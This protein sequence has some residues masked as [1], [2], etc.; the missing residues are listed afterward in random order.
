MK[1]AQ[2]GP[3]RRVQE[4][5]WVLKNYVRPLG[6]ARFGL[7]C[8][9]MGTGMAFPWQ[10]LTS[11]ELAS[12]HLVEDVKLGL[13]L[14]AGGR[15]PLFCPS[16][17][18]ESTFP[19]SDSGILTQRQRW[20]IGSTRTLVQEGPR[21]LWRGLRTGNR[22]LLVLAL[23]LLVPPVSLLGG[24]VGLVWLTC[25]AAALAGH[26]LMPLVLATTAGL[27][28]AGSLVLAWAQFGRQILAMRDIPELASH[29]MQKVRI[30]RRPGHL[31]QWIR[32]DRS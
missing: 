1:S 7:P 8:Q 2:A 14:A 30:Y 25:A 13:D 16:A 5:A 28:T 17:Y 4:L 19:S 11:V 29:M 18:I 9:L 31:P 12:G 20:E 22:D 21:A 15:A 3:R 26:G 6:L 32:T 24:A 23:D 27:L 10:A